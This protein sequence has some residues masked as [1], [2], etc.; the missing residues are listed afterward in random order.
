MILKAIILN[1]VVI[2]EWRREGSVG[3]VLRVA[4]ISAVSTV[5]GTSQG[6]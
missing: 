3:E 5:G 6:N 1:E 4:S 2:G